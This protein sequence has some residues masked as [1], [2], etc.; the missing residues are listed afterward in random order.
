MSEIPYYFETPVPKYFRENDFLSNPNLAAFISWAF[1]RC[2][3]E[4]H[5][6]NSKYGSVELEP[7][8]FIFGRLTCSLETGL[9]ENEIRG[10]IKRIN[11]KTIKK[12]HQQKH[13]QNDQQ[14]SNKNNQQLLE[15]ITSK[16]TNKFTV[17]RWSTSVFLKTYSKEITSKTS[18][19][20]P[21]EFSSESPTKA[22]A[23]AP[24]SR[25]IKISKKNHHPDPS[26][27][28]TPPDQPHQFDLTDD[29]LLSKKIFQH[30][31]QYQSDTK[32]LSLKSVSKE[33]FKD[34]TDNSKNERLEVY[35]AVWLTA[36]E[37][38]E[39]I[40]IKG[41]LEAVQHAIEFIMRSPGRKKKIMNWP[42][43]VSTWEIKQNIKPRIQ[44]HQEIAKKLSQLFDSYEKGNGYECNTFHDKLKDQTGILFTPQ[45]AYKEA[46][47]VPFSDLD[48]KK[49]V[50]KFLRDKKMQQGRISRS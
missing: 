3:L 6:V 24:Q 43:A 5:I 47:F 37:L 36:Q 4:K 27:F 31:I 44:E 48:F 19:K 17:Y 40:A 35:P 13:Q 26:S 10:C 2:S 41:S 21:A 50:S 8:E 20:S 30:N 46:F 49:K 14:N 38:Q 29:L 32:N 15:K 9:T 23:K 11:S 12:K 22:P 34:N 28:S 25:Y 42:N 1:S 39:C 45:N 33:N 18:K 7:F 16:S